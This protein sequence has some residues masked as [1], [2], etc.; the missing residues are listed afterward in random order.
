[1]SRILTAFYS[2]AG[3]NYYKGSYKV[4]TI[5]N[6]Q[7][8]A[9]AIASLTG[10]DLYKIEET[11][12]YSDDYQACIAQA[13]KDL[14]ENKRPVLKNPVPDL[15]RYD[16]IYLCYPNYWGT[17][18]MAVYTFLESADFTGKT[19]Y[20]LCTHEGSGL[21]STPGDIAKTVPEAVVL[22]G[23]AVCGSDVDS[24]EKII[25]KWIGESK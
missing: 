16:E 25:K 21:S 4:I 10:A 23:L 7:K 2:R 12:P 24:S 6:T 3:E 19:I 20:P 15:S 18:P 9:Q 13:K 1:M 11:E 8:A 22:N 14:N 17:M 5:G